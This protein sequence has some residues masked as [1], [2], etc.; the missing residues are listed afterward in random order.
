MDIELKKRKKV[1]L[2][3]LDYKTTFKITE[4]DWIFQ[5]ID[6]EGLTTVPKKK[7]ET[8][9]PVPVKVQIPE[10]KVPVVC[11]N[12]GKTQFLNVIETVEIVNLSAKEV[13]AEE[14]EKTL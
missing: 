5:R 13:F 4:S 2:K 12:T 8:D 3:D 10:G 9:V 1:M 7:D 14:R 11:L 6:V